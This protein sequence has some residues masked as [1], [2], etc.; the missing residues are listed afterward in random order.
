MS[1]KLTLSKN[2]RA[3]MNVAPS[4]KVQV[5][6]VSEKED[7]RDIFERSRVFFKTLAHASEVLVQ[8]DKTGVGEDAVDFFFHIGNLCEDGGA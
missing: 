1:G 6:V 4:K 3:E 8:P 2:V 5:F 7:V